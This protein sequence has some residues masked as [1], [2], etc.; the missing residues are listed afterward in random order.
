MRRG[1]NPA[2]IR[3]ACG[4][5]VGVSFGS[6]FCSEHECGIKSIQRSF[7]IK[8]DI[9]IYGLGRHRNTL[10]PGDLRWIDN[11]KTKV[12]TRHNRDLSETRTFESQ[13]F[14]FRHNIGYE[15]QDTYESRELQGS[16]LRAAWDEKSFAVVSNKESE[17]SALHTI[18]DAIK[19][20]DAIIMLGAPV[21]ISDNPGLT[22]GIAC[23][24]CR[25]GLRCCGQ[26]RYT[27]GPCKSKDGVQ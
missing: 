25:A 27:G 14:Y 5:L 20:F 1:S 11:F 17:I 16:G 2:I 22:I 15:L 24:L 13:G 23:P 8:T 21:I 3:D 10:V 12:E 19:G 7:G 9:S 6:D 26:N 18:F 4:C